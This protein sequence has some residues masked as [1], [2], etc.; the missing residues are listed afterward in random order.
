MVVDMSRVFALTRDMEAPRP[1]PSQS[2]N[3]ARM[4]PRTL[5]NIYKISGGDTNFTEAN[6]F[7]STKG[8][9]A[10]VGGGYGNVSE[11]EWTSIF[12]GKEEGAISSYSAI[13]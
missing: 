2:Q 11:G 4:R 3:P 7:F 10:W 6:E 9:Y 13:P 5:L 1:H 12:G 8:K